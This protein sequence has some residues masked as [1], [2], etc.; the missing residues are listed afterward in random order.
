MQDIVNTDNTQR[1]DI[2][3]VPLCACTVNVPT[4]CDHV[5]S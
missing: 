2:N 5:C 4:N 3:L 1:V